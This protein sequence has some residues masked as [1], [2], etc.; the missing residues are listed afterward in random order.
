MIKPNGLIYI[1]VPFQFNLVERISYFLDPT[2]RSFTV[3]SLH[4]PFFYTPRSLRIMFRKHGFEILTL[5]V[6]DG[7]RYPSFSIRQKIKKILW[8]FLSLFRVGINIEIIAHPIAVS[9]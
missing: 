4:H 1:E 5:R 2:L 8:L 9:R 7:Q 6:F 3:E